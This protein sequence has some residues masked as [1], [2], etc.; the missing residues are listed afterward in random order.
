MTLFFPRE[1]WVFF[2]E[3]DFVS[4]CERWLYKIILRKT[5]KYIFKFY[6]TSTLRPAEEFV[7]IGWAYCP[8]YCVTKPRSSNRR[9]L[10]TLTLRFHVDRKHFEKIFVNHVVT[11]TFWFPWPCFPQIQIQYGRWLLRVFKFS[12]GIVLTEFKEEHVPMTKVN[13]RQQAINY[14]C[15]IQST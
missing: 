10:K 2:R 9:N 14:Q 5:L 4:S 7:R 8:H 1:M 12:S 6:K 11:I 13:K 3:C 15:L